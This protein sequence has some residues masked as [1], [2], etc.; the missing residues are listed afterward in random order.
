MYI[1]LTRVHVLL[2]HADVIVL[3]VKQKLALGACGT[4]R[5]QATAAGQRRHAAAY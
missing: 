3:A 2:E 5:C 4:T 1:I